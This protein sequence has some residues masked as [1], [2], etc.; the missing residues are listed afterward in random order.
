MKKLNIALLAGG[1]SGEREIS[2]KSG[3]AV[4]GALDKK[5]YDIKRYDPRE[6]LVALI[7]ERKG[8][9]LAFVLMHGKFGED[10]C[11]Q[12]FL[13][14][15]GIPFVGSGVLPSA[16]ALNKRVSKERFKGA[17]LKV[18]DGLV[19]HRGQ[20]FSVDLIVATLGDSTVVKPVAEGS[21][22]GVSICH[23]KEALLDGLDLAFQYDEEIIV[24]RYIQGR[25]ITC[26]VMGNSVIETL[27]LVEIVPSSGYAFFDYE[28][29]YTQGATEEICPAPLTEE[30]N[31]MAQTCAIE[32]HKAIGCRVWSRTDMIIEDENIYVLEINTIPGMTETSLVPLSA[33]AAGLSL[34]QLLDKLIGLSLEVIDSE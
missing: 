5:K 3:E 10:G 22:L 18:V 21:S 33:G 13:D 16:M 2:I 1:W 7:K 27:P 4:Y 29:K 31:R 32:A 28:A 24:E 9:D 6:D 23:S 30:L 19:F 17:G 15:L 8:I 11:I 34:T 25:E 26:C 12:G 20:I 14:L